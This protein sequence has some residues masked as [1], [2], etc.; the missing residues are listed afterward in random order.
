V[1]VTCNA[2]GGCPLPAGHNMGRADIPENHAAPVGTVEA[3]L[4]LCER[5]YGEHDASDFLIDD[6]RRLVRR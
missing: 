1:T 2:W 4:D 6:I 5:R 3:I